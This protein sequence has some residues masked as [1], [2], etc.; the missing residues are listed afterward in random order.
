MVLLNRYLFNRKVPATEICFVGCSAER[1]IFSGEAIA[2]V[3]HL[4]QLKY[5]SVGRD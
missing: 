5:Y 1:I 3:G 2:F 4:V